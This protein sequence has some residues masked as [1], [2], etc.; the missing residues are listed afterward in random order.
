MAVQCRHTIRLQYLDNVQ[1]VS[2]LTNFNNS[3]FTEINGGAQ[4]WFRREGWAIAPTLQFAYPFYRIN[5][6][7]PVPLNS[8]LLSNASAR[9]E[10]GAWGMIYF[11]PWALYGYLGYMYQDAGMA[12]LMPMDVGVSYRFSTAR[13]RAGIRG[14]TTVTNDQYTSTPLIRW[15]PDPDRGRRKHAL[16]LGQPDRIRRLCRRRLDLYAQMGS[17]SRILAK[18]LR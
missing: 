1:R 11:Y 12:G 8:L 18:L 16:L 7:A 15:N 14:Y 5:V 13:L 6:N 10:G 17:R 9:I 4:F 3:G 2:K